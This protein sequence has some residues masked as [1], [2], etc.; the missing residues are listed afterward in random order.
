MAKFLIGSGSGATSV[1]CRFVGIDVV[2]I[3][4]VAGA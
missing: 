1:A 4:V 3:D 2:G